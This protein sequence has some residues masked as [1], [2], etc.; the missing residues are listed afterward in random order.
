VYDRHARILDARKH[1]FEL[2]CL[3]IDQHVSSAL[4]ERSFEAAFPNTVL[5]MLLA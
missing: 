3:E 1:G 5:M 4:T 2:F